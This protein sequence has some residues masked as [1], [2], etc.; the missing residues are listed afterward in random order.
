MANLVVLDQKSPE[1][2]IIGGFNFSSLLTAGQT[3]SSATV[4][5]SVW[6]GVDPTPSAIL[7]GLPTVSGLVVSQK[8]TGGVAGVIYKLR[9]SAA[10]SD[11]STQ[12]LVGYLAVVE[13]PL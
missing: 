13:D 4:A 12:I 3:I 9:V 6:A 8:L 1:A 10:A 11:G 7:S 5:A 2:T